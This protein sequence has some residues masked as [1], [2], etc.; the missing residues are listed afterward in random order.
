MNRDH[1]SSR[2]TTFT[3]TVNHDENYSFVTVNGDH[4]KLE[5]ARSR[6]HG[7]SEWVDLVFRGENDG[8]LIMTIFGHD[9]LSLIAAIASARK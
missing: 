7:S 5:S 1:I 9:T 3:A 4:L 8:T 2:L 6:S